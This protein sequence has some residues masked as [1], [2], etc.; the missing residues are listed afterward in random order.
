[1]RSRSSSVNRD[2]LRMEEVPLAAAN[3]DEEQTGFGDGDGEEA[4][5]PGQEE[6][7]R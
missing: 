3:A 2:V 6:E 5:R 4:V 7:A 1:M